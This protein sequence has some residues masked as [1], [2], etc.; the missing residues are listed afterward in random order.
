MDLKCK[1]YYYFKY[2]YILKS[3]YCYLLLIRPLLI[4]LILFTALDKRYIWLSLEF[5][6]YLLQKTLITQ[7]TNYRWRYHTNTVIIA[8]DITLQGYKLSNIQPQGSHYHHIIFPFCDSPIDTS[9]IN[10]SR[11]IPVAGFSP[12]ISSFH[13]TQA[14]LD[15]IS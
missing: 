14:V 10:V 8:D 11:Q 12:V 6:C 9:M 13:Q 7:K 1:M 5:W 2:D 4:L 3:F 15:D